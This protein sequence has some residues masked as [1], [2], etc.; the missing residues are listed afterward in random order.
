M[1]NTI[2]FLIWFAGCNCLTWIFDEYGYAQQRAYNMLKNNGVVIFTEYITHKK[3][4]T[5]TFGEYDLTMKLEYIP[6][7]EKPY[8]Q[9]VIDLFKQFF[10]EKKKINTIISVSD[11]FLKFFREIDE[12]IYYEKK[13]PP[14]LP[15]TWQK[16]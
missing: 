2:I 15:L 10:E 16:S 9:D 7:I 13:N 4:H 12:I 1:K 14:E 6:V 5:K 3:R 8:N 11:R